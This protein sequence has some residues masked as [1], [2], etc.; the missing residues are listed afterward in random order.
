MNADLTQRLSEDLAAIVKDAEAIFAGHGDNLADRAAEIRD[1]LAEALAATDKTIKRLNGPSSSPFGT[2]NDMIR[3]KPFQAV[4][5][6][7]GIGLIIGLLL[8]RK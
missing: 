5:L 2:I 1:R 6:A 8:K 3:D 7:V 4:G